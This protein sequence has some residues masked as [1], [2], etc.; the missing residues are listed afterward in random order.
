MFRQKQLL[1][2]FASIIISQ[3]LNEENNFENLNETLIALDKLNAT[4]LNVLQP[5]KR[6]GLPVPII[7]TIIFFISLILIILICLLV[8]WLFD[9]CRHQGSFKCDITASTSNRTRSII[10]S[11]S[12]AHSNVEF[13]KNEVLL[14]PEDTNQV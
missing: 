10:S 5:I 8:M 3:E 13:S 11:P 14:V 1:T 2:K 4:H 12:L 7:Y 9:R 6:L